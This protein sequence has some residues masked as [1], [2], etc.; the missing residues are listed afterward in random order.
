MIWSIILS[1][2]ILYLNIS[3]ELKVRIQEFLHYG[4]KGSGLSSLP[5]QHVKPNEDEV[6]LKILTCINLNFSIIRIVTWHV[7][8]KQ[9]LWLERPSVDR[10]Q[11]E[12]TTL[13]EICIFSLRENREKLHFL[14]IHMWTPQ[15]VTCCELYYKSI[16]LK[17]ASFQV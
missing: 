7:P 2:K 16:L 1:N 4:G 10:I 17:N 12:S 8:R 6:R 13:R 11:R 15:K 9:M 3:Y 5:C 14:V